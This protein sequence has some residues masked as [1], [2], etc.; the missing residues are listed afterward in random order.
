MKN[1]LLRERTC[2]D[3]DRRIE[4]V[5]RGL[6][7]PE[8]P[9]N[10]DDVRALLR[11]DRSYYT[12]DDYSL[13]AE[14]VGKLRIAGKQILARPM[15]LLEAIRK[16]NLRALYLPDRKRILIDKNVPQ[17]KH[18]WLEGHEIGHDVLPWHRAVMLGDDEQTIT[19]AC[20]AIVE[21][22]ANF[23]AGRLLFLRDRFVE[24]ARSLPIEFRAIQTLKRVFG[25]TMTT[26]LWR[27]VELALSHLPAVGIISFHPHPRC[28]PQGFDILNPCRYFI[29]SPS[30]ALKFSQTSEAQLFGKIV[31][32]CGPQSGG[33]LGAAEIVLT[34]DRQENHVFIFETFFNKFEA[35]TLGR[36]LRVASVVVGV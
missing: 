33:P 28:R 24:N 19:P 26:T 27:Y 23:A 6:G 5:L 9:L 30:F 21:A 1:L 31:N 20:H 11:L 25:N 17:K 35:L 34:D 36:Y 4:R 12:G 8:P 29:Q 32:Y 18:R 14:L 22:E 2:A 15:I 13:K 16:F 3:I 10:L 7:N